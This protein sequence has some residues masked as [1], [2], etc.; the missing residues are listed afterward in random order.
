[1]PPTAPTSRATLIGSIAGI[2][3]AIVVAPI[4]WFLVMRLGSAPDQGILV[5]AWIPSD[6]AAAVVTR[7]A[8]ILALVGITALAIARLVRSRGDDMV[9]VAM[10]V[11][12]GSAAPLAF[13]AVLVTLLGDPSPRP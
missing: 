5:P 6:P 8:S 12:T 11:I 7:V 3:I 4:A 10:L 2:L 1:M 13:F 9:G